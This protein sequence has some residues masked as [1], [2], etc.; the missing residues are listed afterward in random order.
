MVQKSTFPTVGLF[1]Q[2]QLFF[3]FYHGPVFT[4]T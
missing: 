3:Q 4:T 1:N 2:T